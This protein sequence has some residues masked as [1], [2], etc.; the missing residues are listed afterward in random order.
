MDL[1]SFGPYHCHYFVS[2]CIDD[3]GNGHPHTHTRTNCKN[4]LF[5]LVKIYLYLNV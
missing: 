5:S 2:V 1:F 4:L 3:N